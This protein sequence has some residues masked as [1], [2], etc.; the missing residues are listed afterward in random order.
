M[1]VAVCES[2]EDSGGGTTWLHTM[3]RSQEFWNNL[4]FLQPLSHEQGGWVIFKL[5]KTPIT[6]CHGS[7]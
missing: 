5:S 3:S 6:R 1:T 7:F 4:L 2:T